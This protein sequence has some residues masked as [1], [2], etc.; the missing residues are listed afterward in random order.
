MSEPEKTTEKQHPPTKLLLYHSNVDCSQDIRERLTSIPTI[1]QMNS[2]S[3]QC[4]MP[5]V[6]V[7]YI[8][9]KKEKYLNWRGKERERNVPNSL[10]YRH[11]LK[12]SKELSEEELKF[13][14][15]FK[16]GYLTRHF[17]PD[18]RH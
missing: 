4:E 17:R 5:T 12:F 3:F 14:R 7:D 15:I 16:L 6:N 18:I 11:W 1:I 2:Y 10:P 9:P 8:E 13:W